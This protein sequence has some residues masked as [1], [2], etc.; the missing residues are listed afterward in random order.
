M[1]REEMMSFVPLHLQAVD[2]SA[3]LMPWIWSWCGD[4]G[5]KR[6]VTLLQPEDWPSIHEDGGVYVWSPPPA[7]A[8]VEAPPQEFNYFI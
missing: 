8:E 5:G 3:E 7:A 6:K 2:R 4:K 1:S